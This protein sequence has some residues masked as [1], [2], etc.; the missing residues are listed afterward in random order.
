MK[1]PSALE[2]PDEIC[3]EEFVKY[4]GQF[5]ALTVPQRNNKGHICFGL[6]YQSMNSALLVLVHNESNIMEA[7]KKEEQ[8][9]NFL[10]IRKG[11]DDQVYNQEKCPSDPRL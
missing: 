5:W 9:S 1:S 4:I 10:M 2:M 6:W 11:C 3:I 8:I 7:G